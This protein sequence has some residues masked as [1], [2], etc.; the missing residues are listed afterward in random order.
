MAGTRRPVTRGATLGAMAHGR[1]SDADFGEPSANVARSLQRVRETT[2]A[3]H[4]AFQEM[5]EAIEAA[6][7]E[8]SPS[9][10][11][12]LECRASRAEWYL[13]LQRFMDSIR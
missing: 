12:D 10:F 1:I 7:M 5:A 9:E 11:E 8:L 13:A 4:S 6:R 2:A 3:V